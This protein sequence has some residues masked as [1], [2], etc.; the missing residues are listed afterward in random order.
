MPAWPEQFSTRTFELRMVSFGINGQGMDLNWI[1]ETIKLNDDGI[2][3]IPNNSDRAHPCHFHDIQFLIRTA[4]K[5]GP[6][7]FDPSAEGDERDP[8]R[9]W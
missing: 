3:E 8:Y 9:S 4:L 1:D 7:P 5:I 6:S 2:W